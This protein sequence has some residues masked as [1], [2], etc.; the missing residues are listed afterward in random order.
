[1][2]KYTALLTSLLVTCA[3]SANGDE[4]KRPV[5]ETPSGRTN[6]P[7]N[8][9][10]EGGWNLFVFGE[11]LFWTANDDGLYFAQTGFQNETLASPPDGSINFKGKLKKVEP[12]WQSGARIGFGINFPKN[13]Y[14]IV[15]LWTWFKNDSHTSARGALIPLWAEPDF[16]P[17]APATHARGTWNLD[18]NVLDLEWG[19]SSW[20]GGHFSL[21]PFF[22]L[23]GAWIDQTLRVNYTYATTPAIA[24]TVR[25]N[26]DFRG[27]G[28]RAGLDTRFAFPAGFAIYGLASGSLLYGQLG[29]GLNITED[30][31]TIAHTHN[32]LTK[33]ISSV[34]LGF[35]LGWDTHFYKDRL[36][37][38][39]HVGWESNMWF[40]INQMN[41]YM[42]Q[43]SNGSYF[44]E[45]GNLSTQGI[46]AGGRFDF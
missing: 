12:D 42:N 23:R 31:L 21:R 1:M 34:Q 8:F 3:I 32:H 4:A 25:S 16:V 15:G 44:K 7:S 38:E 17:F 41:H 26:A 24:S 27:G 18:L 20:F 39:L 33:G 19:R 36:H 14:D 37:L 6:Y 35:G 13:G 11:Y 28:M 9:Q 29:N 45:D 46:V 2:K 30:G 10:V 22:G 40:K 43:L 5:S